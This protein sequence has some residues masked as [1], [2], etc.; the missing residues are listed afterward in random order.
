M[1]FDKGAK[2]GIRDFDA[3]HIP[4]V[5]RTFPDRDIQPAVAIGITNLLVR[6][7]RRMA[8]ADATRQFRTDPEERR[9]SSLREGTRRK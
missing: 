6:E 2:E 8:T 1:Q 4:D 9:S 3:V 5:L 7:Q